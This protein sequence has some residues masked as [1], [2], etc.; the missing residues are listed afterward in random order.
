MLSH[1]K[2]QEIVTEF[3]QCGIDE[4]TMQKLLA[5]IKTTL[6][7]SEDQNTYNPARYQKVKDKRQHGDQSW[8]EYQR[9]YRLLHKDEIN[10]KR[11]E[12]YQQKKMMQQDTSST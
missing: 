2:Y 12:K 5:V 1:K 10:Q 3:A 9:R 8:N 7:Y 4:E 6:N 11:R